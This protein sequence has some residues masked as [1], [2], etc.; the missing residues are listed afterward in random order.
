[1]VASELDSRPTT[2]NQRIFWLLSPLTY[3][4]TCSSEGTAM[5]LRHRGYGAYISCDGEELD[6]YKTK[7]END[8]VISCY[9][10]SEVGKVRIRGRKRDDG[11]KPTRLQEFRVHWVDST[12][13]SHLSVEVRMDGRRM[14][15]LSHTKQ[16][17]KTS[18]GGFRIAIDA[19]CPYQFAPLATTG[20]LSC[21]SPKCP[22]A[23]N[24]CLGHRRRHA[25]VRV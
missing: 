3:P 23:L 11:K 22:R 16:S 1:M 10:A 14:A 6:A 2:V 7:V 4:G 25:S 8:K 15:T 18:N 13:P 5:P 20:T 9:I 24:H 17:S 12:P 21:S 19:H